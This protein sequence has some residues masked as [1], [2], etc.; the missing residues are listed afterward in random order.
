MV[1][2]YESIM[3]LVITLRVLTFVLMKAEVDYAA[4]AVWGN[5]SYVLFRLPFTR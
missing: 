3:F 5:H 2:D 1:E 4:A